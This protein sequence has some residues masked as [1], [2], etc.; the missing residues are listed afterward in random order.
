[1]KKLLLLLVF[2]LS[3][4]SISQAHNLE[5]IVVKTNTETI[6]TATIIYNS[7]ICVQSPSESV[8]ITGSGNYLGGTF[9]STPGLNIN[10]VNGMI[11]PTSSIP[12][13]YMV[14]YSVPAN[15]LLGEPAFSTT[16]IVVINPAAIPAFQPVYDV[17]QNTSPPNLPSTSLNG[18]T[19]TWSPS[20]I[21]TTFLGT[22]TYTFTPNPGQ[23]A[24]S[25]TTNINI[26]PAAN[27]TLMSAAVTANQTVCFNEPILDIVYSFGCDPNLP[28]V[29][30]SGLPDGLT[31]NYNG[32]TVTVGGVPAEAGFFFYTITATW[33]N[34]FETLTGFITVNPVPTISTNNSNN[35]I[36]V[37]YLTNGVESPLLLESSVVTSGGSST[38]TYQW[39]MNGLAIA[40]ATNANYLVNTADSNG[41]SRIFTV[42]LTDITALGCPSISLG[43]QVNQ[44]GPASPIGIGY[45]IVNNA[46]DQTLTVEVQGY[47]VYG[48]SLDSGAMITSPIFTNVPVGPHALM[49]VDLNGCGSTLITNIDVNLVGTQPPTGSTSQQFSQGAT[50]ADLTVS[51]Q[52]VQWYSSSVGKMLN[53]SFTSSTA[54]SLNTLL[55]DGTTYFASQKIGG[56]ES[57]TRLPVTV[58]LVL[59]NHEFELKGLS[60]QP[61]PVISNLNLK[62]DEIIDTIVVYNLVGQMVL[63][64]NVNKSE[65][66][67]D[68]SSLNPGT[69]F[70]KISSAN[71]QK[72]FKIVKK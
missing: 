46:G 15:I 24:V 62:S 20:T 30:F 31:G 18:I 60:Y 51:G 26:V 40:G 4:I 7:P 33:E 28:T 67:M 57:T 58:Q 41:D 49:I 65:V 64:Q 59:S 68:L 8:I 63:N 12:G 9:S 38:H 47:G 61:N 22:T 52:N 71:K 5:P 70:V 14:T 45:S 32:N 10:A 54:L 3:F 11:D 19:G 55:V 44:S 37:N 1:M 50:L 36:C 43:F 23:C 53:N 13:T 2:H 6:S 34:W 25:T 66:Q 39:Y 27:L 35:V 21:D 69:Y 16:T 72:T 17:C 56:Y 29:V 48:Y 42:E